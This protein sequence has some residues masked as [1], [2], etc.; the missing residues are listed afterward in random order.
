MEL[1]APS[2]KK[3]FFEAINN[4]ADA[5]YIGLNQFSARHSADN[6][7]LEELDFYL[8]YAHL[9]GVKVYCAVNTLVK[10]EELPN[11]FN[12]ILSAYAK[13]V[14]AFIMQDIFLGK[15]LKEQYPEI[16]LHL[17][18]QAGI[19]NLYGAKL[20]KK[21]GFSRVI[22]SR[23][24]S[25]EEIA[26]I[27]KE[28][29]TEIFV[30]GAL[31][32]SFSGH[33]YY[34]SY[35]GGN[36]G[37]RGRCKQPCR[38]KFKYIDTSCGDYALSL[39]DLMLCD[40]VKKIKEIGVKSVKIEGR[41]RSLE[42]VAKSV[43]L[44]RL[45]IDGLDYSKEKQDLSKIYNRGDYT[46][47]Y[48]IRDNNLISD[49]I[50]SHKGSFYSV[51]NKIDGFLICDKSSHEGDCFKIIR[52]GNEVGNATFIHGKYHFKGLPKVG[53]KLYITKDI[54]LNA[55]VIGR[56]LYKDIELNLSVQDKK[57]KVFCKQNGKEYF[58]EEI[59][60]EA[61]NAPTSIEQIKDCFNKTDRYPFK[62]KANF[63][64]NFDNLF[65]LKGQLNDFRRNVFLEIFNSFQNRKSIKILDNII[66]FKS[67]Y[68]KGNKTALIVSNLEFTFDADIFILFPNDYN[69]L[70]EI[71]KR[72]SFTNCKK[73][74]FLFVPAFF[75]NA[76]L[77]ILQNYLD[78]FD[79]IYADGLSGVYLAEKY[80][81]KLF[82]GLGINV[83]N[84][85]TY[86]IIKNLY[87]DSYVVLSKELNKSI[88]Y[89]NSFI[90]QG[91]F[92]VMEFIYCPFKNNC[93][94]CTKNHLFKAKDAYEGFILRRF[95][96]SSCRFM[97]YPEKVNVL[98]IKGNRLIN[99]ITLENLK[100]LDDLTDFKLKT[101]A[102]NK[103]VE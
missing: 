48:F 16:V 11:Y 86:N 18:T 89:E 21:Y 5:V 59:I 23:E 62:V 72:D 50:Q 1:L 54:E 81:K 53:D 26:E 60:Q 3:T 19:N 35:I 15:Y 47:G 38:Q 79:G 34:S 20:A 51:I 9:F 45:A 6:I 98:N 90:S 8:S 95:K 58:S 33:C 85:L 44:Y 97:L 100:N 75:N 73:E 63:E 84:N 70:S 32:S 82:F 101:N 42:Y 36:S 10:D 67:N 55:K 25:I 99:L 22:L 28:I 69:D 57:I 14:D 2:D 40:Y 94:K 68:E 31:C 4:G 61:K 78:Y 74:K 29:E 41:M 56:K 92:S 7:T 87:P 64:G 103:G 30:H 102:F 96:L 46:S 93:S 17:S 37:N 76:D 52:E 66:D 39:S 65:I 71:V 77:K 27:A 91:S 43:R 24:T 49:K 83:F 80:G 13:G 12:L 88:T